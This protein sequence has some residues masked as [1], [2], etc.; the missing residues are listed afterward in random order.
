MARAMATSFRRAYV[1]RACAAA[2]WHRAP[3]HR[4]PDDT[5]QPTEI[6]GIHGHI[7]SD[8]AVHTVPSTASAPGEPPKDTM[9][10]ETA[11]DDE[12]GLPAAI[13]AENVPPEAAPQDTAPLTVNITDEN[14]RGK[15]NKD[16]SLEQATKY[17]TDEQNLSKEAEDNLYDK[18]EPLNLESDGVL[19]GNH[20][21]H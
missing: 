11:M 20:R 18:P 21:K 4:V 16:I 6:S 14:D 10:T 15:G 5:M 8:S 13:G 12:S 3:R 1:E 19:L 7:V 2:P 17:M 9:P